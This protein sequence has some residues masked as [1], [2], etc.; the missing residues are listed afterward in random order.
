V[1]ISVQFEPDTYGVT[2]GSN[3]ALN[4]VLSRDPEVTVEVML[5]TV[6]G[7]ASGQF[8]LI[9]YICIKLTIANALI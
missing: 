5:V 1:P 3:A 9:T 2:E 7:S 6:Q 8:S 4:V